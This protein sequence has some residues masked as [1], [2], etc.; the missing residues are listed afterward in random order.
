VCIEQDATYFEVRILRKGTCGIGVMLAGSKQSLQR[1][2]VGGRSCPTSHGVVCVVEEDDSQV[3]KEKEEKKNKEE[4]SITVDFEGGGNFLSTRPNDIIGVAFCQSD[5][6]M[7]SFYHNG[8]P[9]SMYDVNKVRGTV[10]PAISVEN[11]AVAEFIFEEENFKHSPP[12]S[13]CC[14]LIAATSVL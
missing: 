2:T 8:S 5:M 4:D 6:P 7:L 1:G 14:E 13:R 10:R 11:G 9:I 3:E 12:N